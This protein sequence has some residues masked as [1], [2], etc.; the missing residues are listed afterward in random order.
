MVQI[1]KDQRDFFKKAY[2]KKEASPYEFDIVINCDCIKEPEGAAEIVARAF[3]EKFG[4][5]TRIR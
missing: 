3:K 1:D 4:T 2:G 5:R